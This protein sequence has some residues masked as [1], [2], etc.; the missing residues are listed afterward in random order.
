MNRL[1]LNLTK[2]SK[3]SWTKI[4]LDNE[5]KEVKKKLMVTC[6]Y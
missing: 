1:D 2:I 3:R 4:F 5:G 6:F